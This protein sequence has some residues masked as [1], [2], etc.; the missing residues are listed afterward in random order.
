MLK[1]DARGHAR[2]KSPCRTMSA[3]AK[4]QFFHAQRDKLAPHIEPVHSIV[5]LPTARL[6]SN[7]HPQAWDPDAERGTWL[8]L[9]SLSFLPRGI[10]IGEADPNTLTSTAAARG[11]LVFR[12]ILQPADPECA[13]L[14]VA[15]PR[16]W[17]W[18]CVCN[19]LTQ[20]AVFVP[21]PPSRARGAP[22]APYAPGFFP[23]RP[24]VP[25]IL[26]HREGPAGFTLYDLS[27]AP[28]T[29]YKLHVAPAV[30]AGLVALGKGMWLSTAAQWTVHR[31]PLPN[32]QGLLANVYEQL[33]VA[34]YA[35]SVV[36]D[37]VI[38]TLCLR[39]ANGQFRAV[40]LDFNMEWEREVEV[41]GVPIEDSD[42]GSSSDEEGDD[43]DDDYDTAPPAENSVHGEGG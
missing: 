2:S 40:F 30:E 14:D 42:S 34:L 28:S 36:V 20:E 38:R 19:P 24:S 25:H 4:D 31:R 5:Y 29:V 11:L 26:L 18:L 13:R 3:I 10:Y 8:A 7:E 32:A 17:D 33:T 1:Q 6:F 41:G 22:D 35:R 15:V 37:R 23:V 12:Y 27:A 21:L 9:P 16:K 39:R 43:D